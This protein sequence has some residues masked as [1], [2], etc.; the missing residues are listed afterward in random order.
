[1]RDDRKVAEESG[2]H[3]SVASG[4]LSIARKTGSIGNRQLPAGLRACG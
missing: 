1:M 3:S 2:I 4:Q